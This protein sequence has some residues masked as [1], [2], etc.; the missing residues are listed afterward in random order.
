MF[1]HGDLQHDRQ[2][3]TLFLARLDPAARALVYASAGHPP[4]F[5][6]S[7]DTQNRPVMDT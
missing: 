1:L 2:F 5:V 7:E 6:P 3:V 4:G